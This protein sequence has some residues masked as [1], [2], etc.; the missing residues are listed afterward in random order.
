MIRLMMYF[1][2]EWRID[3][4]DV[5]HKKLVDGKGIYLGTILLKK[6]QYC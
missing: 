5:S 3:G 4:Q 2:C 6:E 1:R